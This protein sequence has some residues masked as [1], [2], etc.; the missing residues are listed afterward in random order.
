MFN[1]HLIHPAIKP[2]MV[3]GCL[4]SLSFIFSFKFF[5]LSL[6]KI[7][8]DIYPILLVDNLVPLCL[9]DTLLFLVDA[10]LTETSLVTSF[11]ARE[12]GQA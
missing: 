2:L 10:H 3:Y 4:M 5:A 12:S 8:C 11:P 9:C 6:N 1:K 7:V